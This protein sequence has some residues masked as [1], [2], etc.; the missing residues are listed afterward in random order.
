MKPRDQSQGE[1]PGR[2]QWLDIE[3]EEIGE[4]KEENSS[5]QALLCRRIWEAHLKCSFLNLAPQSSD[6]L[7]QCQEAA[8]FSSPS[9]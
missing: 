2:E 4:G 3:S 8:V 9:D 1:C 5:S 7:G 6:T